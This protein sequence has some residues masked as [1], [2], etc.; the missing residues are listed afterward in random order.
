MSPKAKMRLLNNS[1]TNLLGNL[2]KQA[3]KCEEHSLKY[4]DNDA[5][6]QGKLT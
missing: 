1:K 5:Q 3:C 4:D 6:V 2:E